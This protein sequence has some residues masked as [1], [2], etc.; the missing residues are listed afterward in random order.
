MPTCQHQRLFLLRLRIVRGLPAPVCA[1][2]ACPV[3]IAVPNMSA[4]AYGQ[5]VP[6]EMKNANFLASNHDSSPVI[7]RVKPSMKHPENLETIAP[8]VPEL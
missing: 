8:P 6:R 7:L 4:M 1:P 2:T 5:P 3:S